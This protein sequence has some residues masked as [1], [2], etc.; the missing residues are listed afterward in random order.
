MEQVAAQ[1]VEVMRQH[2]DKHLLEHTQSKFKVQLAD[3]SK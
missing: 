1:L 2:M 3:L